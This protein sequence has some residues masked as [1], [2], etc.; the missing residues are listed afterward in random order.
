MVSKRSRLDRF[1]SKKL[2]IKRADIRLLLAQK[3]I[4]VDG[5]IA[6]DTAQQIGQFNLITLDKK[7]LQQHCAHYLM[8]HKPVGVV[9]ATKDNQHKTVI[10]LIDDCYPPLHIAGRLDLNTSGLVILTNDGK[11]SRSLS[12]PLSN[13]EKKYIVELEHAVSD[14][15]I[16]AFSE[17]M[18]FSYEN[19]TTKP[20]GLKIT[21]EKT[22]IV[23]LTEGKYHQIK[24]M[25]GRFRNPV[26]KLHRS[27]I[28]ELK[29]CSNLAPGQYRPLTE[30]EFLALKQQ[31]LN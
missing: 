8:L 16:K 9:C 15:Y 2:S 31:M 10:D 11:W 4:Q 13:I 23:T 24:R 1:I 3:R 21:A 25:F 7:I 18:Y 28:G 26:K 20:A 29:L 12:N 30:A 14:D 19:I 6:T 22:V 17:G 5:K 27:A